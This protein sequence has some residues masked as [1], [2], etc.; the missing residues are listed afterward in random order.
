MRHLFLVNPPERRGYSNERSLSGGLGVSRKL[1]F[2]EKSLLMLPPPDMMLTAAVGEQCGL[3]VEIVDLLL[4]RHFDEAAVDY[5]VERI[6]RQSGPEAE[7]WV[8]VRLSIPTLSPDLHFANRIKE[9]LPHVRLFLFG[10]VIMTTLDH[11]IQ[12]TKADALLYGEPE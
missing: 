8:G 5:T 2:W 4:D 10:N 11:W 1:K 6:C 7:V 12:K 3:K 9:R